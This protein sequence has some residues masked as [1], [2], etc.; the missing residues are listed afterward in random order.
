[1]E[2]FPQ[3]PPYEY[4]HFSQQKS[5]RNQFMCLASWYI[6]TKSSGKPCHKLLV[7]FAFS[8][9]SHSAPSKKV[10]FISSTCRAGCRC[11]RSSDESNTNRRRASFQHQASEKNAILPRNPALK[12]PPPSLDEMYPRKTNGCKPENWCFGDAFSFSKRSF[13][14]STLVFG[15]V[16]PIGTKRD[17]FQLAM[18]NFMGG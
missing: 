5:V 12:C 1:M 3:Q 13:S 14:G 4:H 16:F 18:L 2:P 8:L 6:I 11:L 7:I 15:S 17:D 9:G 10:S